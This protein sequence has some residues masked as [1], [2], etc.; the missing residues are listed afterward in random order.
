MS[1]LTFDPEPVEDGRK[2]KIWAV[3]SGPHWLGD[4]SWW[5]PWRRYTYQPKGPHTVLD[6]ECLDEI[7]TFCVARTAEHKVERASRLA[8]IT[9]AV[10]IE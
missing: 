6:A 9:N 2:T 1:R 4:V 8:E 5:S 10:P 3:W 7:A